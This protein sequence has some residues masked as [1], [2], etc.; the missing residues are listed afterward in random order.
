MKAAPALAAG[1][2]LI[3]KA[4]E[5]NPPSNL[6]LGPLA[7]EAS[8][9]PGVLNVLGGTAETGVALSSHVKIRKISLTDSVAVGKKI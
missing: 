4:S 8:V 7:I 2:V 9:S 6:L 3:S 5:M 1:N